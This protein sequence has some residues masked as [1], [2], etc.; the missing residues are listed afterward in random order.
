MLGKKINRIKSGILIVLFLAN[1][2]LAAHTKPL[3]LFEAERMAIANA[4]E[5]QRLQA[6]SQSLAQQAVANGQL[7]D[8]KL[9]A[10]AINVPTNTFSFTQDD[11]TMVEV[12]LEQSFPPGHSLA[13]KS[14]QTQ[15]LATAEQRKIQEQSVM[16]LK[17]VRETWLNLYYWTQAAHIIRT[18]RTLL[19]YLLK[20][21]K[22]QYSVGKDNLS[23]VLQIQLELSRLDDQS[24]QI[25][26]QIDTLHAQLGRWIGQ[27][28]ADRPLANTLPHW[29]NPPSLS[30]MQTRL[31]QHP[32]LKVD[33]AN[34][35]AANDEVAFAREQF[36]PGFTVDVGYGIR[37]GNMMGM[38][39]M[40]TTRSDM[41]TTQVTMD[42]PLFTKNRQDRRLQASTYQ[43][44]AAQLDQQI[45]YRDLLKAL[46]E[47]YAM[48]QRLSQRE[49]LYIQQ[50]V[51][52][53][54]QN[55]KAALLAYQS[56]TT[57]LATVLR[58]YTNER[59]IQLEQLQI[60]IERAKVR[61]ALLYLEGLSQ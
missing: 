16:L 17:N 41:V 42:L 34:I 22:S 18:N 52:E 47:Q 5:L 33:T 58:A 25:Q 57:D 14:R 31:Q 20:T 21:I 9:M 49:N 2:S 46:S 27:D 3:T 36:K 45:H 26:Q 23:N 43:L 11:M 55:S 60:Q 56:A 15:A 6:M 40:P 51:P 59:N 7:P 61:A 44:E 53:S 38:N 37:Q 30:A 13:M 39:G 1:S 24:E 4:P 50:L 29:S 32:L 35:E 10:G 19:M 48:W 28:Q 12:G 54:R 8:P